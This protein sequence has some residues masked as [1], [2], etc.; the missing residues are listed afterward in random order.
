MAV[1]EVQNAPVAILLSKDEERKVAPS[2]QS[3]DD[4]EKQSLQVVP[5]ELKRKL[6]SRHLQMIAVGFDPYRQRCN[7]DL[8][9]GRLAELSVLVCL[10]VVEVL[11]L[12]PARLGV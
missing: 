5:A 11:W 6:K 2:F 10:S 4:V 1:D 8:T 9:I 3:H 7:I 12:H